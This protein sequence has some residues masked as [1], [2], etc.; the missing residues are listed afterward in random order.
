MPK[1][2]TKFYRKNEAEVMKQLGFKP[3]PN[4]GAG[5]VF[6]ED[7]QSEQ[8]ICQLKS[9]DKRSISVKQDDLH[10]LEQNAVVAHKLPVFALQFLNTN[11]VWVMIKPEDLGLIQSLIRGEDISKQLNINDD[12][13]CE[14]DFDI[15]NRDETVYN[16]PVGGRNVGKSYL[17]RQ[18][19]MK[20]KGKEREQQEQEFRQRMKE[21]N[22]ER[23]KQKFGKEV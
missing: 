1:R 19:Y 16:I 7:G 18:A 2:S 5:W 10:I 11:E 23:R 15:D 9:T 13:F 6:K 8:C 17:A 12:L 14:S 4:S 3:T 20:Q 22:R 21:K